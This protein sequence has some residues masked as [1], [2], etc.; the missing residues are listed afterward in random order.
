MLP[1]VAQP[2]GYGNDRQR[3]PPRRVSLKSRNNHASWAS[4]RKDCPRKVISGTRNR[5]MENVSV[6]ASVASA[7]GSLVGGGIEPGCGQPAREGKQGEGRRF[8]A[9][10]PRFFPALPMDAPGVQDQDG[11]DADVGAQS[12]RIKMR[13]VF[14]DSDEGGGS[15]GGGGDFRHQYPLPADNVIKNRAFQGE[16]NLND[17]TNS[18]IDRLGRKRGKEKGR[19]K[20]FKAKPTS[21]ATPHRYCNNGA[22][23]GDNSGPCDPRAGR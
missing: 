15:A 6:T 21:A 23:S 16:L 11:T 22:R 3:I 14:K 4:K 17:V 8:R 7:S 19:H 5:Q 10:P 12:R 13:G 1:P 20:T 2:H 18:F 9:E